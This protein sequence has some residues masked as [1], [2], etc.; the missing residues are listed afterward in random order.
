MARSRPIMDCD[1]HFPP[2]LALSRDDIWLTGPQRLKLTVGTETAYR[3]D[4]ASVFVDMLRCQVPVPEECGTDIRLALHEAIANAVLHGN[5]GLTGMPNTP[6][7]YGLF[8][9]QIGELLQDPVT[10]ARSVRIG[11]RWSARRLTICVTDQGRGFT[12]QSLNHDPDAPHGRGL[13]LMCRLAR[14]VRW[15]Q[16]RRTVMLTF[17]RNDDGPPR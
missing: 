6:E 13:P 2:S 14:Q 15:F 10:R 7:A 11:A 4:V 5:L 12:R 9:Q 17:D 8:C 3:Q 16:H 1:A